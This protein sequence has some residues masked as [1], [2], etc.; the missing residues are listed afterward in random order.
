MNDTEGE[1]PNHH[2][3]D[4]NRFG[5]PFTPL[6][7]AGQSFQRQKGFLKRSNRASGALLL[8]AST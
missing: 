4:G 3:L 7:A 1:V 5:R 6:S 2:D 8:R